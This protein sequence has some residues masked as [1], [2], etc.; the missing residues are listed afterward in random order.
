MK[1]LMI[2]LF[3]QSLYGAGFWTLSNLKKANIYI[4]NGVPLLKPTTLKEIKSRVEAVLKE[5]KIKTKMQDSPTLMISLEEI[6]DDETH[7]VYLQLKIGEEVRTFRDVK[8]DTFSLTYADSDFIDI[9]ISELD[10]EVLES[11]D[12]LLSQFNELYKDDN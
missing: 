6:V 12:F 11:V 4:A 5:N 9:D 2:L 1:Y 3:I 7:Y 10:S 8:T